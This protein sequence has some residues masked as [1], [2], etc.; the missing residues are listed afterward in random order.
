MP[1][2]KSGPENVK[3]AAKPPT[4]CLKTKSLAGKG[5]T[6]AQRSAYF[7]RREAAKVLRTLLQ[8]DSRRRAVGSIKSLVY[9]PSVR[10]KRAVY[11]LVCETL[12][13]LSI[14]KDVLG[15][16]KALNG[17]WKRQEELVYIV[18]YDILF[19]PEDAL[20][21]DA[22]K[23]L[24]L[25]K[26]ALQ[27]ALA[28]LLVRR[29]VRNVNEL[30][31]PHDAQKC[32]YVRVNTLKMDVDSALLELGKK[33]EVQKDD[34]IPDLLVCPSGT[35]LH[36]HPFVKTGIVFLQGK[37][38]S[39]VATSLSPKPEWEVIDACA[40]PGNK[41]VHLA[42]LMNGKG[43]VHACEL[44]KERFK[45]LKH[46]VELAGAANVHVMHEDFLNLSPEDPLYSKV[47]AIL[48]DPSCSGSGTAFDRL[49]HLLPSA[50]GGTLDTLD[51]DRLQ[52]LANFQK[53]ALEHALR[54]PAVERIVYSTCSIHQI[55]NEDVIH[56]LLPFATS[57][58]F[59]LETV[60][61]QW[62]HRGLPVMA[63]SE[64]L[65]RTDLVKDKE[66][67]F[68][69]MFARSGKEDHS[70]KPMGME[71][72]T[73]PNTPLRTRPKRKRRHLNLFFPKMFRTMWYAKNYL[74]TKK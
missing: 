8:G 45:I 39:M 43:K 40:A 64:N 41:T 56:S 22:E 49:D 31:T 25:R 16:S 50:S 11:A 44:D 52:N 30:I 28:R 54:F 37:A 33:F 12:K 21:G 23:F 68:I 35:D 36:D 7:S 10:N 47:R 58:G 74:T 73:T 71:G 9:G 26:D 5:L 20:A 67:F 46:T 60:L 3:A 66:G 14:I 4:K 15:A 53:K 48:L 1:R 29:G 18:T 34:L 65:L 62:P 42:A 59:E 38:S 13:H 61:P 24:L 6:N 27:S 69:A 32:R 19:G 55:E 51:L 2:N 72:S 57:H 63:G 17:K 70:V